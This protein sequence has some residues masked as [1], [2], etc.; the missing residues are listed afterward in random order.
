MDLSTEQKE[1]V[2]GILE[3]IKEEQVV[4]LGGY[5]GTGKTLTAAF[6]SDALPEF[7][8]CAYTGKAADVLRRR[9]LDAKT[10]HSTIYRPMLDDDEDE[11]GDEIEALLTDDEDGGTAVAAK[12]KANVGYNV[13]FELKQ[14]YELDCKG[15][16]IDEGSMVG[17]EIFTDLLSFGLPIIVIGDHGQLPPV[18]E[19]AGL[20]VNPNF[21]LETIHRNAG[22]IAYFAEHLRKGG[23]AKTWK[24]AA[25]DVELIARGDVTNQALLAADQI[26]CGF[27]RTRVGLNTTIRRMKGITT[28][29]P[30]EGDRIMCLR[31]DRVKGVF[32]GQQGIATKVYKGTKGKL[33]FTPK[34]GEPELIEYHPD[35]WNA[36]K[37]PPRDKR[38]KAGRR[39]P[40][41]FAYAI[42]AHKSQGDQWPHVL[43]RE[44]QCDFWCPHRWAY[45][46]AS[47][48]E[49][50]LTW[51]C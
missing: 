38:D 39:I 7:G 30:V 31:N 26:I 8:V 25:G 43:V 12:K 9:G 2:S 45:T 49:K 18:G 24:Q 15:F 16:L 29:K 10:I 41:D 11:E 40:F 1:V 50:K 48:A 19:D 44:E 4:T 33:L 13:K 20:M 22:P 5:A 17:R 37:T 27:N 47:R 23:T 28:S 46:T 51:V 35:A 32:N 6:L 42:T 14:K 3:K 36:E 21:R 34:F